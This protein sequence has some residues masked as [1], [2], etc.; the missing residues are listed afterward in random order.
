M[1]RVLHRFPCPVPSD[2]PQVTK[3]KQGGILWVELA[4]LFLF[5]LLFG[6]A[7]EPIDSE[8][9]HDVLKEENNDCPII[10]DENTNKCHVIPLDQALQ[11]PHSAIWGSS[12]EYLLVVEALEQQVYKI[13]PCGEMVTYLSERT[14]QQISPPSTRPIH[15][16]RDG[17]THYLL[18]DKTNLGNGSDRLIRF[19]YDGNVSSLITLKDSSMKNQ[20]LG[21]IYD[22]VPIGKGVLAFGDIY[23]E[24]SKTWMSAFVYFEP[25]NKGYSFLGMGTQSRDRYFERN[26]Y[27][28]NLYYIAALG[29][30]GYILNMHE[31][32]DIIVVTLETDKPNIKHEQLKD[33]PE[34]LGIIPNYEYSDEYGGTKATNFYRLIEA[35]ALPIGLYSWGDSLYLL[36]K[37]EM[38]A[39]WETEW[40]LHELDPTNGEIRGSNILHTRS[41]NLLI[42]PGER[43]WAFIQKSQVQGIGALRIP[44]METSSMILVPSEWIE[45]I[46][47]GREMT[48]AHKHCYP[49]RSAEK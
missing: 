15:L 48:E 27:V 13:S 8:N 7:C 25:N 24:T 5:L 43:Y 41:P 22:W 31:K 32:P 4:G 34:E 35:S 2:Y 6:A 3:S 28:L 17:E 40:T 26:F 29:D 10:R 1:A 11:W 19:D 12:G 20:S 49:Y 38:D 46:P 30:T 39:N 36:T 9:E 18:E 37:S 42:V 47:E 45:K 23:H 16:R 33:L 14:H 44:Y 21:A